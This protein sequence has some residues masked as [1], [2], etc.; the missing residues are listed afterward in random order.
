MAIEYFG[1]FLKPIS[2][3]ILNSVIL[4]L[5]EME[6][7]TFK[8]DGSEFKICFLDNNAAME[9]ILLSLKGDEGYIC[10][11]NASA[12]QRNHFVEK[13]MI[14][15]SQLDFYVKFEED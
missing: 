2:D 6:D 11:Y 13:M 7:I 15:L 5:E 14:F 8:K 9:N 12:N 10:F 1:Q 4:F 3:E